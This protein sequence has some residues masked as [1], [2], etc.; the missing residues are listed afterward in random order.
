MDPQQRLLLELGYVS[1]HGS[2]RRRA[3]MVGGETGVFVGIE[4]PDWAAI[5]LLMPA[6]GFGSSFL[7]TADSVSVAS[8]RLSFALGLQGPCG[9]IDTACSSALV[10]LHGLTLAL[11]SVECEDG[12]AASVSLKLLP[13]PTLA[14]AGV[15][16]LSSDGR[17]KA[18]DVRAPWRVRV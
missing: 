10:S 9:S 5:H 12:A 18:F 2:G 15:G 11:R 6:S 14:A 13:H 16:M 17:C 1:L 8:G 3:S 4:R 7:V